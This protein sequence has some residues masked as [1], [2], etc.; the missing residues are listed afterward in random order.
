M[1]RGE[2]TAVIT[3]AEFMRAAKVNFM[4]GMICGAALAIVALLL[5]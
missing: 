4:L 1:S 5:L 2:E 3:R